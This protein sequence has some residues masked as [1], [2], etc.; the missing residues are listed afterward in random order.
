MDG[1]WKRERMALSMAV[2]SSGMNPWLEQQLRG[3]DK[4]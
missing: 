4:K 2:C 3:A 1:M